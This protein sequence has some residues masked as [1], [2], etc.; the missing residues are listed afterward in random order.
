MNRVVHH[1]QDCQHPSKSLY[2][3]AVLLITKYPISPVDCGLLVVVFKIWQLVGFDEF[4]HESFDN[5]FVE[6]TIKK[7]RWPERVVL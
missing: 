5:E 4:S 2:V 7:L 6:K 3:A 1:N